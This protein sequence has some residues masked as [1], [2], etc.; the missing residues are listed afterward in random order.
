MDAV[1]SLNLPR[2]VTAQ[3]RAIYSL[4]RPERLLELAY[5]FTLFDAG[6]KKVAR[7]QQY[8]CVKKIMRRIYESAIRK[9]GDPAAWSGIP[10]AAANRSPWSYWRKP[11][12]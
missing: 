9:V 3:D 6:R 10:R 12:R 1:N 8:F 2:V 7:Y 11:L 4:C 5:G